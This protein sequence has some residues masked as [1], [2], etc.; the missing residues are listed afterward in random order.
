NQTMRYADI[1]LITRTFQSRG[2]DVAA[3]SAHRARCSDCTPIDLRPLTVPIPRPAA[4]PDP[5][6]VLAL[7]EPDPHALPAPD[8]RVRL[9]R[10]HGLTLTRIAGALGVSRGAVAKWEAGHQRP[11]GNS[12]VQYAELL[13]LL[14]ERHPTPGGTP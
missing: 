11:R 5:V 9:R 13:R 3:L 10:A 8:E 4:T 6:K 1:G 12:R 2:G 14:A 7:L